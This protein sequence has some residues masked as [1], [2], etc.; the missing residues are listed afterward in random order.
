M[1]RNVFYPVNKFQRYQQCNVLCNVRHRLSSFCKTWSFP[2][3]DLTH[4]TWPSKSFFPVCIFC[5]H[6]AFQA[7]HGKYAIR[8]KNRVRLAMCNVRGLRQTEKLH[9]LWPV[10]HFTSALDR[11]TAEQRQVLAGPYSKLE[12]KKSIFH[13]IHSALAKR[14]CS[15]L[16]LSIL[17]R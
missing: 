7:F 10:A 4:C 3:L 12:F 1:T 5:G 15:L 8:K 13:I 11:T 2:A 14:Q 6:A 9:V 17:Q 16:L